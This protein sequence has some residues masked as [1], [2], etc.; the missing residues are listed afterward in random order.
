MKKKLLQIPFFPIKF[1]KLQS[2]WYI[3]AS[4]F[5]A[6]ILFCAEKSDQKEYK[7]QEFDTD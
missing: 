3:F 7:R 6:K 5:M 4:Q 2:N 1:L